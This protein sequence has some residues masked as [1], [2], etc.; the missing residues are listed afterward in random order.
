MS[1]WKVEL[2]AGFA[3]RKK[4]RASMTSNRF[5]TRF[6][7]ANGKTFLFFWTAKHRHLI[8]ERKKKVTIFVM[9]IV[10]RQ[11]HDGAKNN[12][13]HFIDNASE[14]KLLCKRL[15]GGLRNVFPWMEN[16][17]RCFTVDSWHLLCYL[18]YDS[19]HNVK[20]M[21][22]VST[23]IPASL[24]AILHTQINYLHK[25]SKCTRRW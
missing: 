8:G 23:P 24:K 18:V 25:A 14:A 7:L 1:R 9:F 22:Y 6:K 4:P 3:N 5:Y 20:C 17:A 19:M 15:L 11:K 21:L 16:F 10:D 13:R 2:V 12:K